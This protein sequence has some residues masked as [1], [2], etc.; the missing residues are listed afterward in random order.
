MFYRICY[1]I[2]KKFKRIL[3][4]YKCTHYCIHNK[5]TNQIFIQYLG[6]SVDDFINFLYEFNYPNNLQ[7]HVKDNMNKYKNIIHE[8]T[9]VYDIETTKPIRSAIYGI[10]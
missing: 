4:K 2:C 3:N 1:F 6:I 5:Y 8:I 7:I 10:V 9:I